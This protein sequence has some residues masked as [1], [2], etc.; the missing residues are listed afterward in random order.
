MSNGATWVALL[1]SRNAGQTV[2]LLF[3]AMLTILTLLSTC[4]A[5]SISV[6]T[7][8]RKQHRRCYF[9]GATRAELV[10]GGNATPED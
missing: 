3:P 10:S 9:W 7:H 4:M 2:W 8:P 5:G 6:H 1:A